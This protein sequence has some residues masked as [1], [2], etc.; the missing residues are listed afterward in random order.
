MN[1][2]A[3]FGI[4][5]HLATACAVVVSLAAVSCLDS[6]GSSSD[7]S[8]NPNDTNW[9]C[10]A[11][12]LAAPKFVQTLGCRSDFT[13]MASAPLSATIPGAMT[14]KSVIDLQGGG[15]L[16]FQNSKTYQ[17]H[18]DFASANLSGNG[19]PLVPP[20]SQFNITEYYSP[21]RRFILGSLTYYEGPKIWAYEIAPYDNASAEMIKFAYDKLVEAT[22]FGDSLYFHPTSKTIEDLAKTFPT[23]VKVITTD[24]LFAGID[25]QPLN[26]GSSYGRLVFMTA[27]QLASSYVGFRDIVVLDAVPNDISVT[28]GIVTQEFQ[29]PLSHINVL[30][31]NRGTPNMALKGAFNNAALRALENKWVR[32]QVGPTD[33]TVSEVTLAQADAWW[34]TNRPAAVGVAAMDTAVKDLRDVENILELNTL[35]LSLALKKAIPAFGGK[36]THFGAFPHM[37]T[38]KVKVN[39]AFGVPVFYYWQHMQNAGLNDTVARWLADTAFTGNAAERDIRLKRLRKAIKNAPLD[40]AFITLL[41]NKIQAKF[42]GVDRIRFRSSTNAEDLDGFTGAGLYESK[43]GSLTDATDHIHDA[44]REVWASVWLFRTFEERSFRSI[45]H[46]SVGMAMLVHRAHPTEEAGGVAITANPF[47]RAGLE[48]G[49]YINAQFGGESVVLPSSGI[50]SDQFLYHYDMPGQPMVFLGHSSLIPA[51]TTVLTNT[52]T[53]ALGTALKEIHRFFSAAYGTNASAW[54]AMDT[55]FKL[56]Q[57]EGDPNGTPI[58]IMKQARPYP[59]FGT[60]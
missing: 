18:W 4:S 3:S 47:D 54:Y 8:T 42:P 9:V 58:I 39:R 40:P 28:S 10:V 5:R 30:S 46:L 34:E 13:L 51:G 35:S 29:T 31:Q 32:L 49:F 26:Y 11:D 53:Y 37:D 20:L 16:Y 2:F 60:E 7:P 38:T 44:I 14:V 27:A 6:D 56:D 12:T 22:Y 48:P 41:T 21:S 15:A 59:G 36:T 45:N 24:E 19:K 55:E 50:T 52:Q 43:T 23:S 1:T 57:P 25:F 17:I 33:W